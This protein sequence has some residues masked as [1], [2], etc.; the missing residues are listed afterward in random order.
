MRKGEHGTTVVLWQLRQRE[1]GVEV[2]PAEQEP[3]TRVIPLLRAFTVFNVAR[4]DGLPAPVCAVPRPAWDAEAQAEGLLAASVARIQHGGSKAYYQPSTDAIQLP[5]RPAFATAA[6]CYAT[7]LHELTHWTAHPARCHR[8]LSDRF[9]GDAYAAEELNA[10]MGSAFLCAHSITSAS[11]RRPTCRW[12]VRSRQEG[13][14]ASEAEG[15]MSTI[16]KLIQG[17]AERHQH[18]RSHRNASETAI[19]LGVSP[20]TTPYPLWQQKAGLATPEVTPAMAHG[21]QLEPAA[22]AA[23][24][25]LTGLVMRPLVLVDGVYSASL[26]GTSDRIECV[27]LLLRRCY[28]SR[29]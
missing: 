7:S 8:D 12:G 5:P 26:D 13:A 19:A 9:G 22:R 27:R 18:R 25:R 2:E 23:Y 29:R 4:I 17:S 10:E 1:A 6:T 11:R 15:S 3:T 14:A 24:E 16:V 28:G 20:W 21:T